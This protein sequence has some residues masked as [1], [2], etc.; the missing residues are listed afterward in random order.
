MRLFSDHIMRRAE[1]HALKL[2]K[3]FNKDE[4]GATA[5]E[6]AI[7]ALP[8]FALLFGIIELA[9]VF[10]VNSALVHATSEAGRFIRVGNFQACGAEDQFKALVCENMSDLGNCWKN[11]RIDVVE[12]DSFKTI[13]MP[14]IPDVQPRDNTKTGNDAIPQTENGD[15]PTDVVGGDILVVRAVLHYRLALPP[16][17]T[18]LDDP[19]GSGARTMV[20]TTAFRNEPFPTSGTCDPNTQNKITAGTPS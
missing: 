18:R 10:F 13:V 3:R 5:I 6:F 15:Y 19:K 1:R 9:I 17:L 4:D 2:A 7:V 16:L 11:V 8:F 12:G 20:A 14:D